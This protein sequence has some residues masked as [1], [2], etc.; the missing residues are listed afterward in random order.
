MLFSLF[1]IQSLSNYFIEDIAVGAEHA[2]AMSSSG[3]VFGWGCNADG[4]LGLGHTAF[5]KEPQMISFLSGKN[6]KQVL[7]IIFQF[8]FYGRLRSTHTCF[9]RS[10]QV[11]LTAPPGQ[12]LQCRN[13]SPDRH[14]AL[15]WVCRQA[16]LFN[17]SIYWAFPLPPFRLD[18]KSST[19]SRISCIT[20]GDS[21]P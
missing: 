15:F 1:Q 10:Q 13:D 9:C 20:N 18:L 6:I 19:G 12:V 21:S 7:R 4:Q 8:D 2:L 16:F 3:E 17:M 14:Q 5:V 11:E